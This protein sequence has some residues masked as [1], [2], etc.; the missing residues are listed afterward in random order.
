VQWSSDASFFSSFFVCLGDFQ[1]LTYNV[2]AQDF[3][4]LTHLAISLSEIYI[5]PNQVVCRYWCLCNFPSVGMIPASDL[6]YKFQI[7]WNSITDQ[8]CMTLYTSQW[9]WWLQKYE[10][11]TKLLCMLRA[12]WLA[13]THFYHIIIYSWRKVTHMWSAIGFPQISHV[14]TYQ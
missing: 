1:V 10:N 6:V 11:V 4:N 3:W 13:E 8:V 5:W 2:G 7:I 12:I 14:N 9:K